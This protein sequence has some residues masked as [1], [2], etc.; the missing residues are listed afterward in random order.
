MTPR[1]AT[2]G[3]RRLAR[4]HQHAL[5]E[6]RKAVIAGRT[7]RAQIAAR[8]REALI[9]LGG[10]PVR[11][12]VSLKDYDDRRFGPFLGVSDEGSAAAQ[13]R[14]A[15]LR[16]PKV[17]AL[18]RS[19]KRTPLVVG[20]AVDA[21]RL[22]G[23]GEVAVGPDEYCDIWQACVDRVLMTTN[24]GT[25]VNMRVYRREPRV[26]VTTDS[27][28]AVAQ[29]KMEIREAFAP[30]VATP[31][32]RPRPLTVFVDIPRYSD[33][34]VAG[35]TRLLKTLKAYV[36]SGDAAGR[37][38]APRGHVL[39]LAVWVKKG[40]T[41]R[42]EAIDAVRLA[43]SAG[44]KVVVLDGVKRKIADEAISLAGLLEYFA[45]GH[46]AQIL[47][48][49][50]SCGVR[51]RAANLPDTDTIAR[52][53]WALLN[54]ARNMGANLGKYGCFPLTLSEAEHV[55]HQVQHWFSDWSAAPVF[56]VDQ[57][58]LSD[59]R[60]DVGHDL[61][62][63]VMAWLDVCAK[64]QARVVL[65]DTID[66]ARGCRLLKATSRDRQGFLG[67]GQLQRIDAYARSL[68]IRALWAG[69]LRLPE[70]FEM[71]KLGVFGIYVTTAAA[72]T[73][74]ASGSYKRDPALAGVKKPSMAAVYRTKV[75]LEAG[76]LATRLPAPIGD[77][78]EELSRQLLGALEIPNHTGLRRLTAT[79][80][81]VCTRAWKEYWRRLP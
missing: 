55:V 53:T 17:A 24:V 48:A 52:S 19:A 59:T 58:L 67:F 5:A 14:D 3:E 43:S 68:G 77:R 36:D 47:R 6:Y 2:A 31:D 60:V 41:G 9:H 23:I 25:R 33:L 20:V 12:A 29:A 22:G 15:A 27:A 71:G 80:A 57:G 78:I 44:L 64:H 73:V 56:F 50:H 63:G 34:S 38:H 37:D 13:I 61:P 49:G 69:G 75:L 16:S 18:P 54:T 79:L 65:I 40:T 70:V 28:Q 72:T 7:P 39:G 21:E 62:R 8:A 45:P 32:G 76:F 11:T 30:F 46:V 74:A 42:D 35:R 10:D 81:S 26:V 1:P 66:K 51:V 4:A